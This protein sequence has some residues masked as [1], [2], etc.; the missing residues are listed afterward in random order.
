[1]RQNTLS[2]TSLWEKTEVIV[3]RF[4][5]LI[6]VFGAILF[7]LFASL[8]SGRVVRKEGKTFIVDGR[9]E[10]WDVTKAASIGFQPEKFQYG[11]GRNAFTPLDDS[12]LSANGDAL[13]PWERIIGVDVGGE[14]AAFSVS[15]LSGHEISNNILGGKAIAVGY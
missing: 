3:K 5:P 4:I 11:I 8:S 15:T 13:S 12:H 2:P 14:S 7:L 10:A 1:M 6:I 9:G